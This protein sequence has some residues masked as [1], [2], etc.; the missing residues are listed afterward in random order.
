MNMLI[1]RDVYEEMIV[2][3]Q[4]FEVSC[5]GSRL[6]D[7]RY[8]VQISNFVSFQLS[9]ES[10]RYHEKLETCKLTG[11]ARVDKLRRIQLAV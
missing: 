1:G 5:C 10:A 8:A 2:E 9:T 3:F 6:N 11:L 4:N 7:H